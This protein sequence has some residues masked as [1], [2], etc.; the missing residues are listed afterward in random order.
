MAAGGD[1][2]IPHLAGLPYLDKPPGLFALAALAIRACGRHPFAARL[3]AIV[4]SIVTLLLLTRL[5]RRVTDDSHS[6]QA[7]ALTASAPV[8]AVIAAY[9]IFDMP[10][11]AC[12]TAF[13]TSLAIEIE[14]APTVR[15]RWVMFGAIAIGILV[16]GPVITD[17]ATISGLYDG[18]D[19]A[20]N[21]TIYPNGQ[22]FPASITINCNTRNFVIT[23]RSQ[24]GPY[25]GVIGGNTA[26]DRLGLV[27]SRK[28]L[29]AGDQARSVTE[30]QVGPG[31]LTKN[32]EP[33]FLMSP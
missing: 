32:G 12:V 29:R 5:A 6:W 22:L 1:F 16:K 31:P 7:V 25:S 24:A 4:T 20:I 28:L 9:V 17:P 3:P 10:L 2:V 18:N 13:W 23:N 14:Q 33:V 8:F 19:T 15:G 26:A 30:R 21:T 27:P 11:A